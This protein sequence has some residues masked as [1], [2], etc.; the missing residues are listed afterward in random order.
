MTLVSIPNLISQLK[1][2]EYN[3]FQIIF[4]IFCA[5]KIFGPIFFV[6]IRILICKVKIFFSKPTR[7]TP[8]SVL[9][10][11]AVSGPFNIHFRNVFSITYR[12][13]GWFGP[14]WQ[15]FS[16][17]LFSYLAATVSTWNYILGCYKI[18]LSY[19]S[20]FNELSIV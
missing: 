5:G 6:K 20:V 17:Y 19:I 3:Y 8:R 2:P 10:I 4:I 12:K 7:Y 18:L 15:F 9:K 16:F 14:L 13:S 1:A 11:R